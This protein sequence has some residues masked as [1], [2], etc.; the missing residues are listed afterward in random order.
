MK[1]ARVL[2]LFLGLFNHVTGAVIRIGPF[3]RVR[4]FRPASSVKTKVQSAC[5]TLRFCVKQKWRTLRLQKPAITMVL[6]FYSDEKVIMNVCI[7]T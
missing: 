3:Q 2:R 1:P 4:Q 5:D 7:R 6:Y